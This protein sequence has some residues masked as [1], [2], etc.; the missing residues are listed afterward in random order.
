MKLADNPLHFAPSV[1][2]LTALRELDLSNTGLEKFP[3]GI[4]P[5]L[6]TTVLDLSNNRIKSI[7]ESV[8]LR[9]GFNL[10]GNPINDPSSLRRLIHARIKTGSDIWLAEQ[11]TDRSAALWLRNVPQAQAAEKA[12]LWDSFEGPWS[13]LLNGIRTLSRTP[14]FHVERPLLQR[15][16]WRVLENFSQADA[17]E[18]AWLS[19]IVEFESSPGKMLDWLEAEI[20]KYDGGGRTRRYITGPS[21]HG[22]NNSLGRSGG[23]KAGIP[24]LPV[25]GFPKVWASRIASA[26]YKEGTPACL[27]QGS[28]KVGLAALRCEPDVKRGIPGL[29]VPRSPKRVVKRIT[30]RRYCRRRAR[31]SSVE[32]KKRLRDAKA[33]EFG[34]FSYSKIGLPTLSAVAAT[35]PLCA[36]TGHRA[37]MRCTE[38]P[39]WERACSRWRRFSH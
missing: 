9:A 34:A 27:Y 28:Q 1:K 25:S 38:K 3:E 35:M 23:V 31:F 36:I 20:R 16:V 19:T 11:H 18:R 12:R 30:C 26:R 17:V 13:T 32:T 7:P 15:R 6:P 5:Q 24:D 37:L 33:P 2:T 39:M 21:A 14:E 22:L 10:N 29:P 4:T 8:E